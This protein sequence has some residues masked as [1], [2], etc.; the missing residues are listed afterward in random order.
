MKTHDT[1]SLIKQKKSFCSKL[2]KGKGNVNCS[3]C[4]STVVQN[5]EALARISKDFITDKVCL[6]ALKNNPKHQNL[7]QYIPESLL[8][9]EFIIEVL[10]I[11]V[12]YLKHLP[13][14]KLTKEILTVVATRNPSIVKHLPIEFQ[15]DEFY[16]QLLQAN[17]NTLKYIQK[18]SAELCNFAVS[19][20][21]MAIKYIESISTLSPESLELVMYGDWRN[22]RYLPEKML[23]RELCEYHFKK[24]LKSFAIIPD[25][26]KTEEIC[27]N[28]VICDPNTIQYV[29]S[30]ITTKEFYIKCIQANISCISLLPTELKTPEMYKIALGIVSFSDT[31]KEW[32]K[33]RSIRALISNDE[34]MCFYNLKSFSSVL[35]DDFFDVDILKMERELNLRNITQSYFDK[36]SGL[37][38]VCENYYGRNTTK[39]FNTFEEYYSYLGNDLSGAI[40]VDFDFTGV[41]MSDYNLSGAFLSSDYLFEQ[42]NYDDKFYNSVIG[43]HTKEISNTPMLM[44]EEMEEKSIVH[45]DDFCERLNLR[46]RKIYYVT[47][48]HL[49]HKLLARFPIRATVYEVR[50]FIHNYI[51]KMLNSTDVG[52]DDY[53]LIGGDTSFSFDISQIFFEELIKFWKPQHILVVLGNHELWE[54]NCTDGSLVDIISR[55]KTLFDN[56]GIVFLQ[57]SLFIDTNFS[58]VVLNEK[59]IL[60]KSTDELLKI[61]TKSNLLVFGSIGFSAYNKLYNAKSGMYNTAIS[62]MEQEIEHVH[63]CQNVY[64]KLASAL[65]N[66]QLIVLTHMPLKD[67]SIQPE[68]PN[69]IYVNGH[70]HSNEYTKTEY[71]TIYADNQIGYQ[72]KSAKLKYFYKSLDYD[73][74]RYYSDGIYHISKQQ[75]L[76]FHRGNGIMC[77]FNK[78]VDYIT[79]LKRQGLYLFLLENKHNNTLHILNGGQTKQLNIT[80][81][82]YYYENMLKYG[83]FIKDKMR[84]YNNALKKISD[85]VKKIGGDGRI[86]GGIVDIDFL[87]HIYLNPSDG[88][89]SIYYSPS[90]G[91]RYSYPNLETLLST[92]TPQLY[93]NYNR[94]IAN[95]NSV[96]PFANTNGIDPNIFKI[97]DPSQYKTSYLLKGLQYLTENNIIR[98][99]SDNFNFIDDEKLLN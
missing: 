98:K 16:K 15:T 50:F 1:V 43:N 37:F 25:E 87:N 83:N 60:N 73:I 63:R 47:D 51:K 85:F 80:N 39:E 94:L 52:I 13:L 44:N 62:S 9:D 56:L 46:Q 40:L 31:F 20:K 84:N 3:D 21:P 66:E 18:P 14:N 55:Y 7:L 92:H 29:P 42:K 75:Y 17:I 23:T 28:A 99:W 32:L 26:F 24:N 95:S 79:M 82:D 4:L 41:K 19:L 53:L 76:D 6:L 69:W 72:P 77:N 11:N 22:L 81:L 64:N 48:L 10:T 97:F 35:P 33:S 88:S 5:G 58:R 86:H 68:E 89:I 65:K 27:L 54:S 30:K 93:E 74:F 34:K 67:W 71:K 78:S 61:I 2:E 8:T 36:D 59:D 38:I 91:E 96:I 57:N 70:T 45:S 49:N 12:R 90:R